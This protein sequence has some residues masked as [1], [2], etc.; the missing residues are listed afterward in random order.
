MA[1]E[2]IKEAARK[3]IAE[4]V[5]T[6]REGQ[7]LSLSQLGERCGLSKYHLYRIESGRYN[8]NIDTISMVAA[9]LGIR[10]VI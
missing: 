6:A 10:V 3:N 9:A 2:E 7:G 4:Q 1:P 5:R 8:V